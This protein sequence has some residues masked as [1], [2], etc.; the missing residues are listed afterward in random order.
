MFKFIR[1]APLP[2]RTLWIEILKSERGFVK[3]GLTFIWRIL[4]VSDKNRKLFCINK[5]WQDVS[6]LFS[7]FS[8]LFMGKVQPGEITRHGA[9]LLMKSIT[10]VLEIEFISKQMKR[11]AIHLFSLSKKQKY[12]FFVF[13]LAWSG[14]THEKKKKS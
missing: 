7:L 5:T 2:H 8:G 14:F 10:G 11:M 13:S 12:N 6:A 3:N 9:L 4:P 1:S